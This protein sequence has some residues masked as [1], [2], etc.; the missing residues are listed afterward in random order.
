M[1]STFL[2][3]LARI[4]KN[5]HMTFGSSYKRGHGIFFS[6]TKLY[7]FKD[8]QWLII[9]LGCYLLLDE[10]KCLT[11]HLNTIAG[12]GKGDALLPQS[13]CGILMKRRTMLHEIMERLQKQITFVSFSENKISTLISSIAYRKKAFL[14]SS[15]LKWLVNFITKGL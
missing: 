3:I 2:P 7:L 14:R 15:D 12:K 8:S 6:N 5:N 13:Y 4:K 1:T 9:V 11:H 10:Y